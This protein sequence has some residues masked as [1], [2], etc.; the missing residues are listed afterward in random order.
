MGLSRRSCEYGADEN[1]WRRPGLVSA[2]SPAATRRPGRMPPERGI[3]PR[4]GR[5]G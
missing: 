4:P 5:A 3:W 1:G 2:R